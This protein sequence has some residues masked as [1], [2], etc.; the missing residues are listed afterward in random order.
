MGLWRKEDPPRKTIRKYV[1]MFL[2]FI[3][4]SGGIAGA[5]QY[6]ILKNLWNI[7]RDRFEQISVSHPDSTSADTGA[8]KVYFTHP[9]QPPQDGDIAHTVVS[10]IDATEKTLDV[11]AFELDNQIIT[12]AL[13]RAVRR[14]VKVRLVTE[15]NYL[16]ESG[17]KALK[18]V[19][20]VVVDDKRDGALMH[21][22]FMV[23]DRRAS[24]RVR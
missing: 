5:S 17:V 10:H 21:N 16:E 22:K 2:A 13:V 7:A 6:D 3:T 9:G 18:A 11:C 24:G 4:G 23:F 8:I 1:W 20:V 15:S 19:G 12:D 14:G